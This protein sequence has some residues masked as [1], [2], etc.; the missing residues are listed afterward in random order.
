V[1]EV[2]AQ[3]LGDR[4]QSIERRQARALAR[5]HRQQAHCLLLNERGRCAHDHEV[6]VSAH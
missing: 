5:R 2:A 1:V 3:R 6:D 4:G